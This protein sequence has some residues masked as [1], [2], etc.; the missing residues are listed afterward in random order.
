MPELPEVETIRQQLLPLLPFSILEA[1]QSSHFSS[2]LYE[3]EFSLSGPMTIMDLQRKGKLLIFVLGHEQYLLSHLGMSGSWRVSSEKITAKHTHLQFR[4]KKTYLA[5]VD[6]RR[7]G[8]LHLVKKEKYQELLE[9]LGMDIAS[10]DFTSSYIFESLQRTPNRPIKNTLLDQKL[11]AGVGNYLANEICARAR[12]LPTRLCKTLKASDC[13]RIQKATQMVL[14][15]AIASQGTT[16]HG[17]Y[18]DTQGQKGEGVKNLMVFY[19]KVCQLCRK[20][21]VKKI[22]LNGRGTYFCPRCQD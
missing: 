1:T 3:E 9:G 17:G 19:Q 6:P 18:L 10:E 11:F 21:E 14:Q 8:R 5:Y 4:S 15:G 22:Y 20:T 7:F 13:R 12:L 16:F 2:I